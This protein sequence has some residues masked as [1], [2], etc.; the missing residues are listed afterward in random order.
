MIPVDA[1]GSWKHWEGDVVLELGGDS[2]GRKLSKI[3]DCSFPHPPRRDEDIS[4]RS[5]MVCFF[6]QRLVGHHTQLL[7][8]NPQRAA[9]EL[10]ICFGKRSL[11]S[12]LYRAVVGSVP[13]SRLTPVPSSPGARDTGKLGPLLHGVRVVP[14]RGA[15]GAE[16]GGMGCGESCAGDGLLP[17]AS[18]CPKATR[19]PRLQPPA[20]Q[21]NP[22]GGDGGIWERRDASPARARRHRPSV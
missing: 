22:R 19:C 1:G 11:R 4:F 2:S 7:P 13:A 17:L 14:S 3:H 9:C 8:R 20:A 10:I 6:P 15:C 12:I 21:R 18:P 5:W 16:G